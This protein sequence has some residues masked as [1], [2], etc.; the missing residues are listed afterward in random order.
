MYEGKNFAHALRMLVSDAEEPLDLEGLGA[1]LR[2]YDSEPAGLLVLN[3]AERLAGRRTLRQQDAHLSGRMRK[4]ALRAVKPLLGGDREARATAAAVLV[5]YL[6]DQRVHGEVTI[7]T[8]EHDLFCEVFSA[9]RELAA[10]VFDAHARV[11]AA[12]VFENL[13]CWAA[14]EAA[15]EAA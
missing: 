5:V 1:T 7:M 14:P 6:N 10:L 2:S 4:D 3:A 9:D 11:W 12:A 13:E 8:D 15:D